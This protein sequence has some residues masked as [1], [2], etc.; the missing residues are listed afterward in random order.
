MSSQVG[1]KV[2]YSLESMTYVLLGSRV[3]MTG[4]TILAH[5]RV[6]LCLCVTCVFVCPWDQSFLPAGPQFSNLVVCWSLSH[7]QLFATPWTVGCEA[8]LSMGFS[9]QEYR[10]GLPFASPRDLPDPAIESGSSASGDN[11]FHLIDMLMIKIM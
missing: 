1:Y 6:I 11:S 5:L 8:P 10:S 3:K 2:K 7:V 9:R 4:S